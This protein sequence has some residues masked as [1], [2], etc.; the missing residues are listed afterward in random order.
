MREDYFIKI[1]GTQKTPDDENRVTLL[2][3]GSFAAKNGSY[4]ISYKETEATGYDG[5]TTTVKV[6]SKGKISMI[7]FGDRPSHLTIEQGK[8]HVCHYETG[9]GAFSLGIA[10][11]DV[12]NTLSDK[13]GRLKFTYELDINWGNVSTN[14]VDIT[15]REAKGEKKKQS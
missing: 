11:N 13:G 1:N 6:D 10:A 7:R 14:T 9:L 3:K 15:V 4:F 2:T 5:C 8:R 12:K